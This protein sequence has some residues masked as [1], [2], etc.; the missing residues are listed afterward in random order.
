MWVVRLP[1]NTAQTFKEQL[2]DFAASP[3]ILSETI[4]FI[5][6]LTTPTPVP[7]DGETEAQ[8]GLKI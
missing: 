7:T 6:P 5:V 2:V 8:K 4:S 1:Q 3:S